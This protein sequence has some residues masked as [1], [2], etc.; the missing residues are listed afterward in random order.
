[1]SKKPTLISHRCSWRRNQIH[2]PDYTQTSRW[3][4]PL[5]LNALRNAC[6]LSM[7]ARGF[8]AALHTT[9]K[10]RTSSPTPSPS[11]PPASSLHYAVGSVELSRSHLLSERTSDSVATDRNTRCRPCVNI[12]ETHVPKPFGALPNTGPDGIRRSGQDHGCAEF[13]CPSWGRRRFRRRA[14]EQ[15][16]P[17]PRLRA[18]GRRDGA[19]HSLQR[20]RHRPH[21]DHQGG[22]HPEWPR[23]TTYL[24]PASDFLSAMTTTKRSSSLATT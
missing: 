20:R 10:T 19:R 1:M 7:L 15:R 16:R 4:S 8:S 24:S 14:F 3:R 21:R 18:N 23:S 5:H 12:G 17:E 22:Q 2:Y 11:A 6:S 13:K 9:N